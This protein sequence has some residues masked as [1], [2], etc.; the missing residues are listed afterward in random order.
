MNRRLL[1]SF[2]A[3]GLFLCIQVSFA[4][5]P[6]KSGTVFNK[7]LLPSIRPMLTYEQIATLAG[8]PGAKI[9]ESKKSSPPIIQYRWKGG[10]DSILTGRFAH[11]RMVDATVRVPN[12]K[13]FAIKSNG[14]IVDLGY[15]E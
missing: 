6:G 5:E 11:N 9:G 4:A 8:A 10:R 12:G 7:R 14:E 13:T 3:A 2:F 15:Q 1:F